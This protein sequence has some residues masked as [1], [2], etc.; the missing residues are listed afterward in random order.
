ML[1]ERK[2]EER[3]FRKKQILD[4]ALKVFKIHGIE[5]TTNF[6][7]QNHALNVFGKCNNKNCRK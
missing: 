3:S 7:V 5:K 6:Q 1:S 4:G 2:I